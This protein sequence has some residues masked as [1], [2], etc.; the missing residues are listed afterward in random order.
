MEPRFEHLLAINRAIAE[1]LDYEEVLRLVVDKT[2][3]LTAARECALLLAD[4]SGRARVAAW[5]GIDA[6]R[7]SAFSAL[8][9]ERINGALRDLL[10]HRP[11][12][13][14]VGVPVIHRGH[15]TGVLVVH[16][17]GAAPADPD[18]EAILSALADQAAIALD[19]ASRWRELWEAGQRAQR[20][21]E[22]ASRRKDDF[23]AMLSHELRNPL[24][25]IATAVEVL[26]LATPADPRLA[27]AQTIAARQTEHMKRLLDDL[28]DVSRVTRDRI[29]LQRRP[30]VLQEVLQQ[31]RDGAAPLIEQR[32][33]QLTVD[34]PPAPVVVEGDFDRLVQVVS[35]L[36]TN[37][38]KYTNPGGHLQVALTAEEGRAVVR[39]RDDG[40]GIPAE[41]LP[42]IFDLFVQADR[43]ATRS[44]GGLGIGLSLVKRLVE[45]HGG[46][47]AAAS[48]GPGHGSEMVVRLPLLPA[49]NGSS[50]S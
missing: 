37:A 10:D 46:T 12:D 41:L 23:L 30:V 31:A 39:V 25:A 26:R 18:E 1:T 16:R 9:D 11:G 47:V 17:E 19:H 5:C 22:I 2:M 38:A 29:V 45:M 34:V 3:Q 28:L 6:D 36:L 32:R 27:R 49:A 24:A 14:F 44:E 20:E 35:N 21:L 48:E 8:L 33:H 15:V 50:P 13:A 42:S 7:A 40:I 4:E 43:E